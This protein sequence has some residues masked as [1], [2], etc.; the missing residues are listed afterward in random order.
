MIGH[1][2]YGPIERHLPQA[3]D[4]SAKEDVLKIIRR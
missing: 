4:L 1:G 2:T 3:R